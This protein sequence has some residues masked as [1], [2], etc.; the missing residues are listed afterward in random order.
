MKILQSSIFRALTAIAIGVLL[1]KFPDNTVTGIVIAIGILFLLSGVISVLSYLNARRN[2][3]EFTIYDAQGRQIGGQIPMFPIVG[4]G[5]IVL[6]AFLTLMPSTFVAF[7]MY[8]IGAILLLGAITQFMT[9]INVRRFGKISF[10]YWICPSV[11][12]I[13]GIYLM[14]KPFDTLETTMMVLGWLTLFYG[15]VEAIN[16]MLFY[17]IRRRWEKAQNSISQIDDA[18]EV[19]NKD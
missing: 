17:A 2:R 12:L 8:V 1:I 4:I 6:G 18:E 5:S 11:I 15:I 10:G 19:T 13:A 7:L 3:N 14:L 9:I 16:N